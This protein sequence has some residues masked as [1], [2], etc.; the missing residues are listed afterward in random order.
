M[1]SKYAHGLALVDR[2]IRKVHLE[3]FGVLGERGQ[4]VTSPKPLPLDDLARLTFPNGRPLSPSLKHWLAFDTA[5]L[6]WFEPQAPSFTPTTLGD[7]VR[8]FD[9]AWGGAY[10]QL[11]QR[12]L[13]GDCYGLPGGTETRR[14]L[15]VGHTD[16]LGEYPVIMIDTAA[17]PYV[18]IEYPGLDV[19]LAAQAGVL[20]N[21]DVIDGAH[22]VYGWR[23]REHAQLNLGGRTE[24]E[25]GS[26]IWFEE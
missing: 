21:E 10:A 4:S 5:W 11:G 3:G 9:T 26:D 6:G 17:L 13:R 8:E 2:V 24:F 19:Y 20:D 23:V 12:L 22:P 15:Y 18:A 1:Q 7:Y 16:S 14:F 25:L